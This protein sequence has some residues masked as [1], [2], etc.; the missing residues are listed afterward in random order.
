MFEFS[1]NICYTKKKWIGVI[2]MNELRAY[3]L[4]F[5]F[6][7]IYINAILFYFFKET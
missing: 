6:I 5:F 3:V 1:K 7:H 4:I 2:Y